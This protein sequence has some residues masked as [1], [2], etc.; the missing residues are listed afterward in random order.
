MV[1]GCGKA[2]FVHVVVWYGI[3]W[4]GIYELWYD[5]KKGKKREKKKKKTRERKFKKEDR[6][7]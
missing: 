2:D 7:K 1:R 6:M 4:Y 3:V 5:G